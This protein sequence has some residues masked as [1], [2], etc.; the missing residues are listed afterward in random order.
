MSFTSL[1][2]C[3]PTSWLIPAFSD[4]FWR[5]LLW[6]AYFDLAGVE[7]L[8]RDR[9]L[10]QFL[11][12]QLIERAQSIFGGGAESQFLLRVLDF[13]VGTFEVKARRCFA[14]GLIDGVSHLLKVDFGNHVKTG[15]APML[16]R[17]QKSRAVSEGYSDRRLRE[18][19]HWSDRG[20]RQ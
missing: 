3:F 11:L 19:L 20:V 16:D 12:Q 4:T 5:A 14:V 9:S 2:I 10:D 6:L 18:R 13:R 17:E 7:S 1:L 15:H 8:Q